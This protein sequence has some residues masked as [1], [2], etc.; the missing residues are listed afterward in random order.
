[1]AALVASAGRADNFNIPGGD[2]EP[3]LDAY[4]KQTGIDLI[5]CGRRSEGRAHGGRKGDLSADDALAAPSC[6][7]RA[8]S[9]GAPPVG[10]V[11]IARDISA[12]NDPASECRM[13]P[14]RPRRAASGAALETVTVT[15][16][17]I[18]GDVQNIP[19]SITAL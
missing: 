1:M 7:E 3:A 15:S 11:V 13:W 9:C 10:A 4:T 16:S 14:R 12:E 17:K 19:I 5:C 6:R 2:L 18:G 8:L